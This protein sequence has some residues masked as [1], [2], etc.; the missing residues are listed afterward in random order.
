MAIRK[1]FERAIKFLIPS[2]LSE[3]EGGKVWTVI[4]RTLD[5]NVDRGRAALEARFPSRAQDDA[6]ALIGDDRGIPRG[7]SETSAHYAQRLIG[8]RY[9]RGHVVRGSAF[10]LLNQISEYFGGIKCWTIDVKGN[11]HDRAADGTE[12]FSYG[13]T[14]VWDTITAKARFWIVLQSATGTFTPFRPQ[15]PIGSPNLYNGGLVGGTEMVG[16]L[17]AV[18]ADAEAIKSLF[19]SECPWKP[20][21]TMPVYAIISFGSSEPTPNAAWGNSWAARSPAFAYWSMT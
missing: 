3:G 5:E 9:P 13:N 7:R 2:W 16:L 10:A 17:G 14:W 11:R 20:A 19:Y 6:L 8:W 21:G 18:P 15:D 4:T 12:T 1:T